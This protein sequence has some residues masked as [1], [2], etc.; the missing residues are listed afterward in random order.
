[1]IT[2]PPLRTRRLNVRLREISAGAAIR[3][4][5]IKAERHEYATSEFLRAVIDTAEATTPEHV[6]DPMMWTVQERTLAVCHY[7]AV[8]ASD[9]NADF[10]V[11][12][13]KMSDYM[14]TN[15]D[16][17]DGVDLGVACEDSWRMVPMTGMAAEVIELLE[18]SIPDIPEGRVHWLL[19]SM[20]AQL[21]RIDKDGPAP[22]DESSYTNWLKERMTV[23]M[24]FPEGDFYE[25]VRLRMKGAEAL[26]HLFNVDIG[27]ASGMLAY[28]AGEG[29][30]AE[31]PPA[32]FS[33]DKCI[34][35]DS[36][37]YG[38]VLSELDS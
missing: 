2:I 18:G 25:L 13:G 19:G 4:A 8:T 6:T 26:K 38:Q 12:E 22:V 23:F 1:M 14:V 35:E 21:V 24:N 33:V 31:L 7:M 9:G 27:G 11:G 34:T 30:G 28:P 29:V 16:Y 17:V 15:C 32:R 20:A 3:L 37:R 10:S 5:G 36:R